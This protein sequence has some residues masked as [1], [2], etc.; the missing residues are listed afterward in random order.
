MLRT[1]DRSKNQRYMGNL[2]YKFTPSVTFAWEWRRI[3]TDFRNQRSANEQGDVATVVQAGQEGGGKNIT[4]PR[5]IDLA[6]RIRREVQAL[7]AAI[8]RG[9]LRP[10][11]DHHHLAAGAAGLDVERDT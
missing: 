5:G 11:G 1:G 10:R 2:T 3:L 7:L 6:G 9:A 8:G 4:G